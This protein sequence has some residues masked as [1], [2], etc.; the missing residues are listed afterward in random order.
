MALLSAVALAKDDRAA[1]LERGDIIVTATPVEGSDVPM[2]MVEALIEAPP[3]DIWAVVSDCGRYQKTMPRIAKSE[4]LKREGNVVH[5]RVTADMPFPFGDLTSTTRGVETVVPGQRWAREWD[6]VKGDYVTNRGSWELTPWKADAKR[7]HVRY[8][9]QAE[10]K[11]ALPQ[12][13]INAAQKNA[14]P[15]VIERLRELTKNP[16][17]R[18]R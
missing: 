6:L 11:L 9:I 2:A 17:P 8:R 14:L 13:L 3:E 12:S 4:L 10:P 7:T 1:R 5:C 15:D 16:Q 18:N